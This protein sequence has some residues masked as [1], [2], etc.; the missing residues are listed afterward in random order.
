MA[1]NELGKVPTMGSHGQ[2]HPV[3]NISL[4]EGGCFLLKLTSK[5]YSREKELCEGR[6]SQL[7]YC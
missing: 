5:A 3:H 7:Q 4:R 6:V 1:I 2:L